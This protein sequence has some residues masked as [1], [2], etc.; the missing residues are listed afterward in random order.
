[1]LEDVVKYQKAFNS[2]AENDLHYQSYFT[3]LVYEK[4]MEGPPTDKDWD[5]ARVFGSFLETSTS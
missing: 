2:M 5:N 1:M 3:Y 4:Q